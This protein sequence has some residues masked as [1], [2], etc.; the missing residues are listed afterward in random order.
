MI[1]IYMLGK[2][3]DFI[4]YFHYSNVKREKVIYLKV[5]I[6]NVPTWAPYQKLKCHCHKTFLNLMLCSINRPVASE[7]NQQCTYEVYGP[8]LSAQRIKYS[9]MRSPFYKV[10][11]SHDSHPFSLVETVL[12][13]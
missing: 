3:R 10:P 5:T 12:K 11:V 9:G 13:H 7:F 2:V 6:E 4:G 1:L 8:F